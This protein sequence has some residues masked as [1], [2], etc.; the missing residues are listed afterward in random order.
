[1]SS[2]LL[3]LLV[4]C[5][6]L[7]PASLGFGRLFGRRR[8]AILA[9]IVV[10]VVYLLLAARAWPGIDVVTIHLAIF[11]SLS[12][13][14]VLLSGSPGTGRSRRPVW[15]LVFIAALFAVVIVVN[16]ALVF[17]AEHGMP[18]GIAAL[19]L[20]EPAS[21]TVI[22]SRFPGTVTPGTHKRELLY[23]NHL[24]KIE[25]QNARGWTIE[26]GWVGK[27][28]AGQTAIF[29][30]RIE[31]DAGQPLRGA[32]LRGSFLRPSDSAADHSFSMSETLGGVYQTEVNLPLAGS[33]QLLLWIDWGD[34]RHELRGTT[35]VYQAT[36]DG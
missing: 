5:V 32:E 30:V 9:L 8:G 7:I 4:G 14:Y 18:S 33:W 36:A 1:M 29:R 13:T 35:A 10:V 31:D 11:A 19:V 17:L 23:S 24:Q 22:T 15:A 25:Q 16:V 6:L 21:E 20:P 34:T 2:F 3:S 12:L 26:K 28:M 27:P